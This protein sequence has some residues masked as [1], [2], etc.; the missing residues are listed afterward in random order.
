MI[1]YELTYRLSQ[2][3]VITVTIRLSMA[4]SVTKEF[5]LKLMGM[6]LFIPLHARPHS[7]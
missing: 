3:T 6:F 1:L 7:L 5:I 4:S 2:Q